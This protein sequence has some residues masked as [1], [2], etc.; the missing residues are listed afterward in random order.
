MADLPSRHFSKAELA[1]ALESVLGPIDTEE[2]AA[3]AV[4]AVYRALGW[5]PDGCDPT[6][7][8]E[9]VDA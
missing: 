3:R 8:G 6:F 5:R 4:E 9:L 7:E 2:A 1:A